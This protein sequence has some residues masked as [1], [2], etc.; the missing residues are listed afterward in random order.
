MI[1]DDRAARLARRREELIARSE[2]GRA[3]LAYEFAQWERPRRMI[4]R[5]I[6]VASYLR[7]RPVLVGLGFAVLVVVQRRRWWAWVQRGIALWGVAQR[8]RGFSLK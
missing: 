5:L 4:D 2:A 8:L 1:L 7:A 3:S 6:N